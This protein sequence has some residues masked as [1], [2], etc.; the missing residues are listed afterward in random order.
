MKAQNIFGNIY[1][2]FKGASELSYQHHAQN[3]ISIQ[4]YTQK[5][6]T[7]NAFICNNYQYDMED[8]T[9]KSL[10][11]IF[12][13]ISEEKH[14]NNYRSQNKDKATTTGTNDGCNFSQA[15]MKIQLSFLYKNRL[16]LR[17]IELWKKGEMHVLK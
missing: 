6:T 4:I 13:K 3:K 2:A 10:R 7:G 12:V 8:F 1:S 16:T 14:I 17:S 5:I 15:C 11:T 9:E